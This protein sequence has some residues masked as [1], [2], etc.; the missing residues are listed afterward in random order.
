VSIGP[1]TLKCVALS[2]PNADLIA[3]IEHVLANRAGEDDVRRVGDALLV[4]TEASTEAIRD[5]L[6][7]SLSEDESAFVFEFERWSGY[8]EAIDRDWLRRR[9]H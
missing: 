1:G 7:P 6:A 3:A 2:S 4:Y 9:G 5:W 8:G